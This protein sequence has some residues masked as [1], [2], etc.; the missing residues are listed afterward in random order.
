VIHILYVNGIYNYSS[1]TVTNL[2][3]TQ[4]S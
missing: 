1:A 3:V 2:M 4:H